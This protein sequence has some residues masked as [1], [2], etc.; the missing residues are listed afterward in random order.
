M[1]SLS[2]IRFLVGS[3]E[4]NHEDFDDSMKD[5]DWIPEQDVN[6]NITTTRI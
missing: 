5:P 6:N 1:Y 2:S 3:G 4:E